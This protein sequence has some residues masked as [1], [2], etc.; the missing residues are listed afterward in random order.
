[1]GRNSMS[2]HTVSTASYAGAAFSVFTGF[3]LTEWGIVVGILT[4]SATFLLN[5]LYHHRNDLRRQRLYELSVESYQRRRRD[6]PPL[7]ETELPS[8]E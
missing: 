7:D 5:V 3:T 2:D 6:D 4:A 8:L 1:M